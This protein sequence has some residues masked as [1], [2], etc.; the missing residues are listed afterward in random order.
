MRGTN[1]SK[2]N[3]IK[4]FDSFDIMFFIY[5][6]KQNALVLVYERFTNP[7]PHGFVT[8][9]S[10]TKLGLGLPNKVMSTCVL[11]KLELDESKKYIE[12]EFSLEVFS[13]SF[14]R[15]CESD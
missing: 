12:R 3:K 9:N 10:T 6:N 1:E 15:V 4:D 13:S 7:T 5:S 8:L 11:S 14:V 2:G